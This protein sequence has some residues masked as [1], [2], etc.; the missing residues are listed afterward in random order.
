MELRALYPEDYP[1]LYRLWASCT[2]MGLNNLDDSE[3]GLTRFLQRNPTSCFAAVEDGQ[4]IGAIL[5]GSDG[6][7]GYIYHTAVHPG[8]QGRGIGRA[9][10]ERTL[11][12]LRA[13][14]IHKVA[15][16]VF[17]RNEDGNAFWEAMGFTVREDI[18]YRNRTLDEMIRYD[19]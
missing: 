18:L 19:S 14:G 15:L 5:A 7:R 13:L 16:V 12:A 6:R 1:S 10:V 8:C 9:L 2:G 11:D 4:L 3:E 17:R